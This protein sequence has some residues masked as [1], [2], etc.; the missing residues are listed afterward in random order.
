MCKPR[1]LLD[2]ARLNRET[3][4]LKPNRAYGGEGVALGAITAEAEWQRLLQEASLKSK[5][6]NLSWVLQSATRLPI[7]E[8]PMTDKEGRV[9][10]EPYYTVMGFAPTASSASVQAAE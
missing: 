7:C 2:F 4:V 5:D 1:R 10:G 9:Y 3:L 6:P 8:F